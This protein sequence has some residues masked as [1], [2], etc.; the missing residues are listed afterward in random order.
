MAAARI[1]NE[2]FTERGMPR[3]GSRPGQQRRPGPQGAQEEDAARGDFP[4]DEASRPLREAIRKEGPGEGG[5][6]PPRPQARP[7]AHAARG[8]AADEAEAHTG[9][10]WRRTHGRAAPSELLIRPQRTGMLHAGCKARVV[11][12]VS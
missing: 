9:R 3:A 7:Q 11:V 5:G 8:P 2:P 12:W 10:P 6:D 1:V 4:R